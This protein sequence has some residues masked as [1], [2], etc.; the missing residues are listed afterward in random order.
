LFAA[1]PVNRP[2]TV[3]LAPIVPPPPTTAPGVTGVNN[4]PYPVGYPIWYQDANVTVVDGVEERTGGLQLTYCPPTDAMCI[5]APIDLADPNSVALRVG[6]E[7][8]F[9]TS[10]AFINEDTAD[11]TDLPAGLDG[12]L[13]MAIEG[14]FGGTGVPSDGNQITFARIRVRVDVP[15]A[16]DYTI[17]H[18]YGTLEFPGVTVADGINYTDDVMIAD[19]ANPDSGM[20]GAI[21]GVIGPQFLTWDTFDRTLVANPPALQRPADPAN[22]LTSPVI[23]YIG[24]PAV[25]H[26]VT[27]SPTGDNFFR[28][29]GPNGIDVQTALFAVTGKVYDP[30]TFN[31]GVNSALPIANPDAATLNLAQAESVVIA[32]TDND[33]VPGGAP[34]TIAIVT[35]PVD[36]TAVANNPAGTITYTPAAG[37]G[38]EGGVDTFAYNITINTNPLLVSNNAEVTV[39]VIPEETITVDRAN[40]NTRNLRLD[41]RGTSNFPGTTLTIRAGATASG[42][43]IGTV[44]VDDRG[45]WNFRGTATANVTSVTLVSNSADATTVTQPLQVR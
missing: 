6:E 26:P 39:T 11:V 20:I 25:E 13:V 43:V 17:T 23:H 42:P 5:S 36:G 27:G 15:V 4:T 34:V 35:P 29:E 10:E 2:A 1:G 8:F 16:G 3:D 7:G 38:D 40:F 37:L 24:D 45:R 28:I 19:P 44:P 14:A 18:P 33:T 22:P 12:I 31:L 30:A 9:W 32:V 41:L 21:Y